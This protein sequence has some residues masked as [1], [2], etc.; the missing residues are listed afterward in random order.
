MANIFAVT[1]GAIILTVWQ[2][3]F[4]LSNLVR[5]NAFECVTLGLIGFSTI[6]AGLWLHG[7]RRTRNEFNNNYSL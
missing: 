6:L 4:P 7:N 2:Q 5:I 3:V 1:G